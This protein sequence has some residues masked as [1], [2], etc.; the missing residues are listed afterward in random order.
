[1]EKMKEKV[2]K[3]KKKAYPFYINISY[4][5]FVVCISIFVVF[6]YDTRYKNVYVFV[7]N[8]INFKKNAFCNYENKS[9]QIHNAILK[10]M[11]IC[12]DFCIRKMTILQTY[13]T[14]QLEI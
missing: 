13:R 12:L 2:P 14:Q 7:Q 1:M 6:L 3:I 10:Y 11:G 4:Y 5:C 8:R 9:Y